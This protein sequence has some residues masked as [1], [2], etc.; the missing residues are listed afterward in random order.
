MFN[1]LSNRINIISGGGRQKSSPN[2]NK[3]T[4][5]FG[6]TELLVFMNHFFLGSSK[7]LVIEL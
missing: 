4:I 5:F 7:L 3:F 1:I 6:M 2:C